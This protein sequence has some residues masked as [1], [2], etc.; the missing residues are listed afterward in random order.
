M[1]LIVITLL[2]LSSQTKAQTTLKSYETITYEWSKELLRLVEQDKTTEDCTFKF[3]SQLTSLTV[4]GAFEDT[5]KIVLVETGKNHKAFD[6]FDGDGLNYG[7]VIDYS[8][9]T[10]K[11]VFT[12]DG[13]KYL[14]MFKLKDKLVK[15]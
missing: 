13:V 14:V 5:W 12:S 2:L 10:L 15:D 9:N 3:N 4:E 11:L 8:S 7:V 1:R 6:A